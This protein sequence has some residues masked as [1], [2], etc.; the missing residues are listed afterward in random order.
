MGVYIGL[1]RTSTIND[2]ENIRKCLE[3]PSFGRNI[4]A[5][6]ER[7]NMCDNACSMCLLCVKIFFFL[8]GRKF[9]LFCFRRSM[10]ITWSRDM[11]DGIVNN[12][13]VVV[14]WWKRYLVATD[15][16]PGG[17]AKPQVQWR[18]YDFTKGGPPSPFSPPLPPLP[19]PPLPSL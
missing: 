12:L 5:E 19:Y 16:N 14:A 3:V 15:G 1:S 6:W 7:Q 11:V 10:T 13:V 9:S 2:L 4:M 18:I 17:T 8:N